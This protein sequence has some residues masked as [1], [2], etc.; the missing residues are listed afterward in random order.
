M[1]IYIQQK[2]SVNPSLHDHWLAC[3]Y[4]G[5][6][7]EARMNRVVFSVGSAAAENWSRPTELFPSFSSPVNG[8]GEENEPFVIVNG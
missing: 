5:P 7:R 4:S 3:W 1:L 6:Q 2:L 8:H